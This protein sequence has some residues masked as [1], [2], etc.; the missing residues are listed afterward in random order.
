MTAF[1][2]IADGDRRAD[3]AAV[4]KRNKR[5]MTFGIASI[6]GIAWEGYWLHEFLTAP[7]PDEHMQGPAA[8][9]FGAFIPAFLAGWVALMWLITSIVRRIQG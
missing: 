4:G 8:L 6:L 3:I 1:H 5:M 2:P 7:S 9:L